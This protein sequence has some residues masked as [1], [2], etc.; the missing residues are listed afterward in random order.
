MREIT[1]YLAAA[2]TAAL[3]AFAIEAPISSDEENSGRV[4]DFIAKVQG[5]FEKNN[6]KKATLQSRSAQD[7]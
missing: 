3:R 7:D 5:L 2:K 4:L 6:K 1:A